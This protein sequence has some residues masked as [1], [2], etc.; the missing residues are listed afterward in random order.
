MAEA[1][2]GA[3]AMD[4]RMR[5]IALLT[6]VNSRHLKGV[7]RRAGAEIALQEGIEE[8]GREPSSS[9]A[10]ARVAGLRREFAEAESAIDALE[11]E[12]ERLDGELAKLDARL[13]GLAG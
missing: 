3:A 10:A 11:A 1:S 12:R 5:L 2:P 6:E 4:E 7:A 13:R 8:A 9:E